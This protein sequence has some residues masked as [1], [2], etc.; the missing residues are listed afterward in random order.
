[1][2]ATV[3]DEPGRISRR[4]GTLDAN[5]ASDSNSWCRMVRSSR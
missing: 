2:A 4:T 5:R 3:V 1:M